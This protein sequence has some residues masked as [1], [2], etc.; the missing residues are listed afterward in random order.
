MIH[1]FSFYSHHLFK[2]MFLHFLS[3]SSCHRKEA[4]T[5][6][7]CLFGPHTI[8]TAMIHNFHHALLYRGADKSLARPRRKQA[9]VSVR[10]A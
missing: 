3:S 8:V 2:Q 1:M 5:E 9:N 6:S 4:A 10:M 7:Q